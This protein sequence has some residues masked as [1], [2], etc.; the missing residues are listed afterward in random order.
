MA[1]GTK[2][3]PYCAETI[4]AA[5]IKCRYCGSSLGP[6]PVEVIAPASEPLAANRSETEAVQP[7]TGDAPK[8]AGPVPSGA[9]AP[10]AIGGFL[11]LLTLGLVLFPLREAASA[12]E[13]Y[14]N[15]FKPINGSYASWFLFWQFNRSHA[16]LVVVSV[17]LDLVL[18]S[19][20]I[21][22]IQAYFRRLESTRQLLTAFLFVGVIGFVVTLSTNDSS[23]D[24]ASTGGI[25]WSIIW[26]IYISTGKRPKRTFVVMAPLR[27]RWL[28]WLPAFGLVVF[29][30]VA[31]AAMRNAEEIRARM[32]EVELKSNDRLLVALMNDPKVAARAADLEKHPRTKSAQPWAELGDKGL[33]RLNDADL[34][35]WTHLMSKILSRADDKTCAGK[36]RGGVKEELLTN[37]LRGPE[38][39]QWVEISGRAMLAEL[40][41]TPQAILPVSSDSEAAMAAVVAKL[42]LDDAKGLSAAFKDADSLS[43]RQACWAVRIVF[44]SS[45]EIEPTLKRKAARWLASL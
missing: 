30:W 4:L 8:N 10:P 25:I 11:V 12:W 34:V 26:L 33:M 6:P 9:Q 42:S 5:A 21:L 1:E 40:M 18:I 44:S 24:T 22:L 43:D 3:C 38:I 29:A 13:T 28:A 39:D 35:L 14:E 19:L 17:V 27:R 7:E 15:L 32:S 20:W 2:T 31:H 41:E 37:Y 23:T 36:W 45:L 16:Y